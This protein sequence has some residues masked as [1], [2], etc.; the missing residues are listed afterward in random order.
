MHEQFDGDQEWNNSLQARQT[1]NRLADSMRLVPW[2]PD[3]YLGWTILRNAAEYLT[4]TDR[5]RRES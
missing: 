5:K 4:E 2:R 3:E 1:L